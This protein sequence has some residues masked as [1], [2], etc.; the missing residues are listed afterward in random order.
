MIRA[1]V[2]RAGRAMPST[3]L[4]SEPAGPAAKA[5]RDGVVLQI[6]GRGDMIFRRPTFLVS[7]DPDAHGGLGDGV[8]TSDPVKA[9]LFPSRSAA[10]AEWRRTSTVRPLRDDGQ[11]NRPL[12]SFTVSILPFEEACHAR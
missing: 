3:A 5:A 12:S 10:V 11:P 9:R 2:S 6:H 7:F 8:F 4:E 1:Q